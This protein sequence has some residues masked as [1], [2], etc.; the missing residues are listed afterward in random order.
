M[1][2]YYFHLHDTVISRDYEGTVLEDADAAMDHAIDGIR[3][4]LAAELIE[5]GEIDFSGWVDVETGPGDPEFV[6]PFTD[7]VRIRT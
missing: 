7:A 6:V 4:V 5:N 3:S 2:R 1:P